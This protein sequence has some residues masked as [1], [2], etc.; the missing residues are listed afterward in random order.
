MSESLISSSVGQQRPSAA[1]RYDWTRESVREIY[2]RSLL[3]LIFA[4][5]QIHRKFHDSTRIQLCRLLSIKTGGC[6][7][8]CG[9]CPQ[10]AH[11]QTGVQNQGLLDVRDVLA[12]AQSAKDRG[13]TRFCIGAAWRQVKD[14]PQFDSVL[15]MVRGVKALELEACCTLG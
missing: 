14:G 3:D 11:Y 15:A 5:Q 7:E 10:S 4:A 13:A 8:D 6:P 9:Y 2:S 1:L 12:A